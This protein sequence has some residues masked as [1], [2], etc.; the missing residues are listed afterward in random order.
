MLYHKLRRMESAN[1]RHSMQHTMWILK[2]STI[3][4]HR[5]RSLN[6]WLIVANNVLK[7][8]FLFCFVMQMDDTMLRSL[9][10]FFLDIICKL[11]YFDWDRHCF[12]TAIA[13]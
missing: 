6:P 1:S 13:V 3:K 10:F 12:H 2:H 8:T 11:S 5:Y 7:Q 4:A 9:V